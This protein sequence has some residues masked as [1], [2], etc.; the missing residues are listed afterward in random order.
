[1]VKRSHVF[2]HKKR[3][4]TQKK[5]KKNSVEESNT[6]LNKKVKLESKIIKEAILESLFINKKKK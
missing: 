4:M 3:K 1:M 6:I 2:F 5:K